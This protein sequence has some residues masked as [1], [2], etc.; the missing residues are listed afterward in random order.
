MRW[1]GVD[2]T[3]APAMRETWQQLAGRPLTAALS[4]PPPTICSLCL[5]R[6]VQVHQLKGERSFHIFYQLVRGAGRDKG[7]K[8]ELKLP[9]KP[10][11]FY[12]LSKSGCM[13]RPAQQ[14]TAQHGIAQGLQGMGRRACVRGYAVPPAL[15]RAL[16]HGYLPSGA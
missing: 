2:K 6:A 12:Y 10:S 5:P 1:V 4:V 13:V 3:A 11:E 8:A 15:R 14:G 16:L 9:T 7:L